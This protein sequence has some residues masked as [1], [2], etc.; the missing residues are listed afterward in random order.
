MSTQK[1]Y[2]NGEKSTQILNHT[3]R[4]WPSIINSLMESG[5]YIIGV[6]WE[7]VDNLAEIHAHN[8]PQIQAWALSRAIHPKIVPNGEIYPWRV[9]YTIY[10]VDVFTLLTVEEQERYFPV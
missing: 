10:G 3:L 5:V 6:R 8:I 4:V 9:I 2:K 7:S 1:Y